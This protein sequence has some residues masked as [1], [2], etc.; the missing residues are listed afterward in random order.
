M[1]IAFAS[2]VP[3]AAALVSKATETVK[4]AAAATKT[5]HTL[6]AI[7]RCRVAGVE[8]DDL[9]LMRW[10]FELVIAEVI[11]AV[12][13]SRHSAHVFSADFLQLERNRT[14]SRLFH[15][16]RAL[17]TAPQARACALVS[18]SLAAFTSHCGAPFL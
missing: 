9:A 14:A 18:R 5:V 12:A 8:A 17:L 13:A 2:A 7:E 16:L 1:R 10:S 11:V 4:N 6:N 15:I 3:W